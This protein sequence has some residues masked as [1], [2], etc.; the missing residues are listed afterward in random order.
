[1]FNGDEFGSLVDDAGVKVLS[2]LGF[3]GQLCYIYFSLNHFFIFSI[4][5]TMLE[6]SVIATFS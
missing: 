2:I 5:K 4:C 6:T 1:M 3:V